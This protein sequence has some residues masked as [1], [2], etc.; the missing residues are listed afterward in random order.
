MRGAAG[1]EWVTSP[2]TAFPEL[3]DA[4]ASSL[5]RAVI[6]LALRY[7]PDIESWMK[8]NAPWTDRTGNARQTLHV[9]VRQVVN[10]MVEIVLSH[11]VSYGVFLELKNAGRYAIVNPALDEFAPKIWS[12]VQRLVS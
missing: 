10:D 6:A 11:G 5:H 8:S 9:E 12:D 3:A 1:F 7:A 2:E 4:Y